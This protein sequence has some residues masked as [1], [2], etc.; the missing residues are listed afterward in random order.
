VCGTDTIHIDQIHIKMGGRIK[1]DAFQCTQVS[2]LGVRFNLGFSSFSYYGRT[3]KWIGNHN[4]GMIGFSLA[5]GKFNLGVNF[6]LTTVT[7]QSELVFNGDTL[8]QDAKLNPIKD[9]FYVSYSIDLKN[10]FS[11]E[12]HLGLTKN[13]FFII[14]EKAL[15]KSFT[16]PNI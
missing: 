7:P 5:Y 2:K 13:L 12:P 9:D 6:K 10:N 8:T 14:N 1:Y 3:E 16:I 4:A 11:I 15:N